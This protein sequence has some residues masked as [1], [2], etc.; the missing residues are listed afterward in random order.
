MARIFCCWLLMLLLLGATGCGSFMAARMVQAPNSYPTWFSA[1]APV[2]LIHSDLLLTNFPPQFIEIESP[3]A[4]LRYRVV[5]PADYQ[6]RSTGTN[7]VE[8]GKERAR[9]NFYAKFPGRTNAWTTHPRGTVFLL[10]GYGVAMFAMSPWA[11][12][13]AQHGWRCV[14][15][16]LR[17]HGKSTGDHIYFGTQEAADLSLILDELVKAQKLAPPVLAV[18]H[19]YGAVTA[20]RWRM[21]DARVRA[22]VAMSP[23]AELTEAV[24]N[25]SRE[26]SPWLPDWWLRAGLKKLPE[27]L[28]VN[29]AEF[30]TRT[31]I[32]RQPQPA[33]FIAATGDKITSVDRVRELF[34]LSAPASELLIVA[35]ATHEA[36]PYSFAE[37]ELILVE[38][39]NAAAEAARSVAGD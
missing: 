12:Q 7:W 15:V 19:S 30:D 20:L 29:V 8:Q 3:P 4:R 14:L 5:E 21:T 24:L 11:V 10:H 9:F 34:T 36:L 2:E 37:M 39:L 33:L 22:V 17:G 35:N 38:W 23:Y 6:F 28:G 13:L 25:I 27:R 31:I 26:Y 18:G 32:K 16:D 1:L